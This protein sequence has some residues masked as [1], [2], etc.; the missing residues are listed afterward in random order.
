MLK[1]AIRVFLCCV[2]VWLL[3]I[4]AQ[5]QIKLIDR[6]QE[7]HGA[8]PHASSTFT[9]Q[10]SKHLASP[11]KKDRPAPQT[12][13]VSSPVRVNQDLLPPGSIAQPETQAEPYLHANPENPANLIAVYQESRFVNGGARA[14]NYSVSFDSGK[15]WKEG[16]L[17]TLTTAAGGSWEKASDPWIA[18]GP[19]NRAYFASLLFNQSTRDNAIGISI[20]TDGGQNWGRPVEVFHADFDFNDKEAVTV[21]TN[22]NSP[23]FGTVY[24]AWDINKNFFSG[25]VT[26]QQLVVARSTNGGLT[27]GKPKRL[28]KKGDNVGVVPRVG[29]DGTVYA[30]WIGGDTNTETPSIFFSKST[31]GGVKWSEAR[32]LADLRFQDVP[33]IRAGEFIVG[34][35]ANS[36]NGDLYIVWQDIRWTSTTGQ[37]TFMVSHDKGSTWSPPQRIGNTPDDT[38]V[39][40]VSLA[41]NPKGEVAVSY[42]TLQND[43]ERK[44]LVDHYICISRNGGLSF[45]PSQRVTSESLDVRFAAQTGDPKNRYF[46]GDYMGL[47][48]TEAGFQLLWI[49][50]VL[51]SV[52]NPKNKQPD[53]F[54][55]TAP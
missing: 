42:F 51:D 31:N 45:E 44:F 24:V 15:T 49:A 13:S 2:F 40:T 30:V 50:P 35:D 27:W 48:G 17:P 37:L 55:A 34:F 16:I 19:H 18:F 46:L 38:P 5:A 29:P 21:D 7:P 11:E 10:L 9:P 54:T 33:D 28:R 47:T 52:L 14:L 4:T 36:K 43:P 3:S 22:P 1:T 20:S 53:V 23:Y 41:V 32:A 6:E 8:F 12:G 39:F 25:M 26:D